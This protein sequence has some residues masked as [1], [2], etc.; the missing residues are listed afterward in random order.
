LGVI[1][2]QEFHFVLGK[3]PGGFGDEF[4]NGRALMQAGK[5]DQ[6]STHEARLYWAHSG[7]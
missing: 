7:L 1:G 5:H 2:D 6:D 4:G 3:V